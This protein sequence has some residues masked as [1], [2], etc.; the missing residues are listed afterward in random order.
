MRFVVVVV[1]VAVKSICLC[2][3]WNWHLVLREKHTHTHTQDS[4]ETLFD[5]C[6]VVLGNVFTIYSYAYGPMAMTLVG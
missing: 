4:A 3:P 1:V 5:E 2:S 6:C